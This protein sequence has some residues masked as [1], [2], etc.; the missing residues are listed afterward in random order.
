MHGVHLLVEGKKMSKS[1]G[2]FFTLEDLL[3]K[4]Y[5]PMAIRLLMLGGHYRQ[6]LNFTLSGLDAA[7][8]ALGKLEKGIR[9]YLEAA[10]LSSE[11]WSTLPE[12]GQIP[13][14]PRFGPVWKA[15]CDDLNLPAAT[16]ALHQALRGAPSNAKHA[17]AAVAELKLLVSGVLGLKLFEKSESA[18]APAEIPAEV[19]AL[20]AERWDAKQS[21]DWGRA[22]A[23]RAELAQAGWKVLD[24]KDGYELEP[25]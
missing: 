11:D 21:R 4:G 14:S 13:E 7:A 9:R 10:G 1:L 23:L 17:T 20:A 24:R 15:L 12:D 6:Q 22:D 25:A 2:N 16:G 19:A 18:D 5:A 8:S 3:A